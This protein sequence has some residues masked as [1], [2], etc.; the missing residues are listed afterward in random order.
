MIF[1]CDVQMP[2]GVDQRPGDMSIVR[3]RFAE[4]DPR[5]FLSLFLSKHTKLTTPG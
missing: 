2:D 5:Y 4:W 3:K 1:S